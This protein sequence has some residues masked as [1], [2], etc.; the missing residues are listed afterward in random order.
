ML[1]NAIRNDS[2]QIAIKWALNRPAKTIQ[3]SGTNTYYVAT[4]SH[5]VAMYWVNENDAP[6]ILATQEKHCNCAN[7][8][9]KN[10]YELTNQ[11][12]VNLH[13]C[14]NRTCD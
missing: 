7:G 14:G 13:K 11:I 4:Y 5:N 2:G 6:A 9:Y 3:M 8:I 12:D 10:A 1:D